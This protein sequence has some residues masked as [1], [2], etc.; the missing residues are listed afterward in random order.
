MGILFVI[1]VIDII[2]ILSVVFGVKSAYKMKRNKCAAAYL[3]RNSIQIHQKSD[4]FIRK[5]VTRVR[6]SK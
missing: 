3:D 6:L 1:A 2:I 4:T 5:N